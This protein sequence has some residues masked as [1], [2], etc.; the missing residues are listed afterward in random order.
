MARETLTLRLHFRPQHAILSL[1]PHTE[2]THP[3]QPA[4]SVALATGWREL[5]HTVMWKG[6]GSI[7]PAQIKPR[8]ALQIERYLHDTK[9]AYYI[10]ERYENEIPLTAKAGIE[11]SDI[12]T[13]ERELLWRRITSKDWAPKYVAAQLRMFAVRWQNARRVQVSFNIEPDAPTSIGNRPDI[14]AT[15]YNLGF[16]GFAPK[17]SPQPNQFGRN[18][19]DFYNST[20]LADVFPKGPA[21]QVKEG[22]PK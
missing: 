5:K 21:K 20:I 3:R 15:L 1:N 11:W 2:D 22:A 7:G 17:G 14:L 13:A 18:A 19:L 9:C 12:G 6:G 16:P 4:A 10:G 8:V